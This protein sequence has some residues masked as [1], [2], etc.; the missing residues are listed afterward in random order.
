M[1][2]LSSFLKVHS[3]NCSAR[4]PLVMLRF[5]LFISKLNFN[6]DLLMYI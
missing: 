2:M 1:G 4:R 3:E 5:Y 6:L